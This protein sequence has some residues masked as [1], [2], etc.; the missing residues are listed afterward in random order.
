MDPP[1][2]NEI[3]P[4]SLNK[5]REDPWDFH[6]D[7]VRVAE[8]LPHLVDQSADQ[9][10]DATHYKTVVSLTPNEWIPADWN[11][12]GGHIPCE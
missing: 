2:I 3:W 9:I 10:L 5:L 6:L 7:G 4:R 12:F 1:K 8:L 11:R